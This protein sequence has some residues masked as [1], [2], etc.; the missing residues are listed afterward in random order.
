MEKISEVKK[1][2]TFY[3]DVVTRGFM[4]SLRRL[5][6][7]AAEAEAANNLLIA[8]SNYK[9][10]ADAAKA[11][12]SSAD[13]KSAEAE[14]KKTLKAA[15]K[16]AAEAAKSSDARKQAMQA[17]FDVMQRKGLRSSDINKDFL[18]QWLPQRFNANKTIC[19]VKLVEIA[20]EKEIR[21][22]YADFP[23]MLVER[24]ERLFI[25]TPIALFTA[26]SFFTLF[27]TAAMQRRKAA[28]ESESAAEK[29]R[30]E[31]EKAER[32][33]KSIAAMRAKVAAYDAEQ[34]KRAEAEK[35]A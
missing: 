27:L 7:D 2:Y 21:E 12:K 23:Q 24:D 33:A 29:E 22:K 4:A 16:A 14:A 10:A 31:A 17:L 9:A 6:F 25:Y 8:K 35:A 32:R 1:V 30:K 19:R 20:D 26:N 18:L 13:A 3:S 5:Q 15:Q 28:K 34:Q 11:A